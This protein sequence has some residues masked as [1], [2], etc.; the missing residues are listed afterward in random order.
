MGR[1]GGLLIS[2]VTALLAWD[3]N[4]APQLP[5]IQILSKLVFFEKITIF[6][7]QYA[8]LDR[9]SKFQKV[10]K[11]RKLPNLGGV[12]VGVSVMTNLLSPFS[13][14][15]SMTPETCFTLD[16]RFIAKKIM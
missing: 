14:N 11:F 16:P 8:Y 5:P 15:H 9:C 2:I 10:K 12:G 1:G 13:E 4:Y 7:V 3:V 6:L